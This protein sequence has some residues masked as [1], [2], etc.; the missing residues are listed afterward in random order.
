VP[1][2]EA[3]VGKYQAYTC[4]DL[5][6]LRAAGYDGE[7]T[8]LEEGVARYVECLRATEGYYRRPVRATV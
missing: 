6:A 2:P 4:A 8:G 7:F 3:L 1:F 5:T